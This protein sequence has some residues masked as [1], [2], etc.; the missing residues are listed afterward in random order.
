M[1]RTTVRC[2]RHNQSFFHLLNCNEQKNLIKG[3]AKNIGLD[4]LRYESLSELDSMAL[5]RLLDKVR[6]CFKTTVFHQLLVDSE[7]FV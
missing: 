7:C 2:L 6:N 1:L 5:S 3:S 4:L